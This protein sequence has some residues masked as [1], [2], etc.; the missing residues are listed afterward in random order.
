[1]I[2]NVILKGA[3]ITVG[4]IVLAWTQYRAS[5]YNTQY[6]DAMSLEVARLREKLTFEYIH[7]RRNGSVLRVYLMNSGT[8][9]NVT[10]QAVYVSNDTWLYSDHSI[11]LSFLNGTSMSSFDKGSEGYFEI[12]PINLAASSTY[13]VRVVTGRGSGFETTYIAQ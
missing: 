9:G 3:V 10:I 6:G 5:D 1:M 8:I 4:F 12:A 2:S 13:S 7:Y 11:S